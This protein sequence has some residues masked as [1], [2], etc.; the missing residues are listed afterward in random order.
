MA[1]RF[2]PGPWTVVGNGKKVKP[3]PRDQYFNPIVEVY[4]ALLW[5]AEKGNWGKENSDETKANARLIAAAPDLY[6]ALQEVLDVI[7]AMR[8]TRSL[9]AATLKGRAVLSKAHPTQGDE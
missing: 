1:E 9:V 3:M 7:N 4:P 2:T 5:N 8:P 6:E